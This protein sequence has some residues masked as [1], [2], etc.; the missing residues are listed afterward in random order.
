MKFLSAGEADYISS[1]KALELLNDLHAKYDLIEMC[2]GS[3]NYKHN[4]KNIK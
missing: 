2:R 1:D 3:Q 4:I